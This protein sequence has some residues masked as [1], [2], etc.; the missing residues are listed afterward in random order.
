M[1]E[2]VADGFGDYLE[3]GT[4]VPPV[5]LL[6]EKAKLLM[7]STPKTTV[8]IVLWV[9]QLGKGCPRR[10]DRPKMVNDFLTNL[11]DMSTEWKPVAAVRATWRN[12]EKGEL[13]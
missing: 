4:G 12:H 8:L 2:S 3:F 13:Q 6:I 10:V 5:D 7:L 9:R 11:P 1:L